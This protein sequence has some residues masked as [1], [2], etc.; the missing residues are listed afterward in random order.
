MGITFGTPS[1]AE[2]LQL[3]IDKRMRGRGGAMPGT[4]VSYD[5]L[6]NTCAVDIGVHR[7]V[8][9]IDDEDVDEVEELPTLQ[10]VPVCWP[11]GRGIKVKAKLEAGDTVMLVC[12]DRDISAWRRTGKPS[13]PDDARM[14][15]WQSAVAVPGLVPNTSPFEDPPDAAALASKL[16]MLIGILAG[17]IPVPGPGTDGG[18]ALNTAVKA[19]FPGITPKVVVPVPTDITPGPTT[20]SSVLLLEEPSLLP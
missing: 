9:S 3:A 15:S 17:W 16:D 18:L 11:V 20:G 8:P 19:Y 5:A 14:G 13:E 12:M 2:V 6:K 10:N 1:D 7:L 4:V